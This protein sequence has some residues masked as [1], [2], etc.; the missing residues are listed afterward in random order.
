L[1]HF[2]GAWPPRND[3]PKDKELYCATMLA[4]LRPWLDLCD[5]KTEMESFEE[6]FESFL[7]GASKETKDVIEN[8]QYYYECYDGAKKRQEVQSEDTERTMDYEV[9]AGVEDLTSDSLMSHP[10]SMEVTEDDI[11]LAYETRG[12]MREQLYADIALNIA[13]ECGVFSET[14]PETVFLPTAEK[15]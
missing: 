12:M 13:M 6:T 4:L 10:E 14:K 2:V 11:E 15:A 7:A 5:L 9:D 8:I 1:P 3:R